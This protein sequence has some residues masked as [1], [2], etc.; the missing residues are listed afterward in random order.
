MKTSALLV[1]ASACS[2]ASSLQISAPPLPPIPPT[3]KRLFLVRHGEVIPPGGKQ[4]VFY[5]ALDV[6]LSPLGK[7]EADVAADY[8]AQYDLTHVA[9][10]HLK[11]AIYGAERILERQGADPSAL[12]QYTGFGEL[13]RGSWAGK[14]KAQIGEDA[15][16]A[17]NA[18]RPGTTPE[19][20]ESLIDLR[21]RVF[22]ARDALLERTEPGCACAEVSHL[23]VTRSL[24]T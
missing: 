22:G 10:S 20:G 6:D 12:L 18:C 1:L 7:Q 2:P 8:L 14:T 3:S 21:A 17:F 5:G 23:W 13:D 15:M 16:D 11:R 9:S 4:G 19:G 24:I